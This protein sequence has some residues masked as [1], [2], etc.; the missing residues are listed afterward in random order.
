MKL[1]LAEEMRQLDKYAEDELG[2]PGLL[3]MEN[4]A[5]AVADAAEQML[6]DCFGKKV[7]IFCGKGNNGGDGF[8]AARWLMNRGAVVTVVLAGVA[9][10][11]A[12]AVSFFTGDET[13]AGCG[14]IG[15]V[16]PVS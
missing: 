8:G 4:A 7:V 6:G 15:D 5:R 9:T 1:V 13:A 2:I 10:T 11:G 3:L 12:D 16:P 14:T